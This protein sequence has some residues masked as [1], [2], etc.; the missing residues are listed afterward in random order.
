[1]KELLSQNPNGSLDE[2][3]NSI[4]TFVGILIL[5]LIVLFFIRWYIIYLMSD[6]KIDVNADKDD[7]DY[8]W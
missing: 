2:T 3:I 6:S 1:M 5:I 7:E 8:V 4:T